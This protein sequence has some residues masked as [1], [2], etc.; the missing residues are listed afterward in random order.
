MKSIILISLFLI[1]SSKTN[2]FNFGEEVPFDK[3]NKYF[4]FTAQQSGALFIHI[5]FEGSSQ[6]KLSIQNSGRNIN[7]NFNKPGTTLI[8]EISQGDCSISII[9]ENEEEKGKFWLNPSWNEI[10]VDL[11]KMYQWKFDYKSIIGLESN[12]IYSIEN[13]DKNVTLKFKYNKNFNKDLP[14][15]FKVCR[16][17]DCLSNFE[18]YDIEPGESYKI[19]VKVAKREEWPLTYY[20]LPSFKFG[21]VN[22]DWSFSFN[23]KANLWIISLVL[24]LIL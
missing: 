15:P 21:D 3:D 7:S 10:K 19:Y 5:L 13:A 23:L 16:G 24:L 11:S 1:I 14:N 9:C 20:Y 22:G 6:V 12:L 4:S 17:E 2:G 18:T 8:Y